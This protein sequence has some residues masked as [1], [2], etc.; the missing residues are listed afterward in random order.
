MS[1]AS[2]TGSR[3]IPLGTD[4]LT[5]GRQRIAD[6]LEQFERICLSF[7]GG[8]DSTVMLHLVA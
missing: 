7:S 3:K 1:G 4:V 6:T 8:K 2:P 5:A